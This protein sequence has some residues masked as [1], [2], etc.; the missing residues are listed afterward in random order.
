MKGILWKAALQGPYMLLLGMP[1]MQGLDHSLANPFLR[2]AFA[3]VSPEGWDNISFQ[4]KGGFV[5]IYCKSRGFP[6]LSI[7]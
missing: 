3:L 2:T 6:K 1:R 5:T 4:T 7:P